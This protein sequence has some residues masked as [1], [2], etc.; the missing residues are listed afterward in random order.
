MEDNPSGRDDVV[1]L[2]DP[3]AIRA[4]AHPA[5]IAVIDRL[6]AGEVL[7]ATECAAI[8]GMSPS[9]MSYHLRA[10]ERWGLVAR[11]QGA[12][13][14]R[15]RPWRALGRS[16]SLKSG[17]EPAGV[18]ATGA[19]LG[20]FLDR[21]RT[22]MLRA[23]ATHLPVPE[24]RRVPMEL[25]WSVERLTDQQVKEVNEKVRALL[26]S[27]TEQAAGETS[28]SQGRRYQLVWIAVPEPEDV[29]TLKAE[30]P[31]VKAEN[32][33]VMA[34]KAVVMAEKAVVAGEKQIVESAS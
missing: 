20:V 4:M 28:A 13:D 26:A 2:S 25:F 16:I 19:V 6:F 17:T 14:A 27:V 29:G 7:T 34:E 15:E 18:V 11:V 30:E 1:V 10:L 9:A 3:R 21:L 31:V 23:I 33:V 32:A 8:T 22:S 24:E 12:A 5:R